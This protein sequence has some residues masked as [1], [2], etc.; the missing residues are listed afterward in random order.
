[1]ASAVAATEPSLRI[2]LLGY[3]SAP[4]SGGQGI[5][6]H[7]LSRAL[8]KLGHKV[9][10]IS[11]PPYPHLVPEVAL[12]QLP[13][14]DL[15]ANGLRSVPISRLLTD[16]LA[17]VE[18]LSKLTGGFAEPWTFAERARRWLLPRLDQF[19]VIHDNQTLADGLLAIQAAG[20]PLVTTIHHPISRDR[21]LALQ[22]EPSWYR[23][24]LVARWHDFVTMQSRV[25]RNLDHIVTVSTASRHDIAADF[26]VHPNR[27]SVIHIGVDAAL[28]RPLPQIERAPC[29]IMATASA[30][31]PNKGLPILLRAAHQLLPTLPE[32]K[33]L[34][35]GKPQPGGSTEA[36]V[37]ELGMGDRIEWVHSVDHE[38]IVA[39]YARSTV[40]VVPSLYEGFGLPAVEAMACAMP[41][42]VSDGGALPE[43]AG[44]AAQVVPAGDYEALAAALRDLLQ[45]KSRRD[46]LGARAR[47][48][49]EQH[50]SWDV[51][52]ERMVA[53]Y[54][55]CITQC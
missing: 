17:R 52:A 22:A 7:Y 50:F 40:A 35:V 9:T 43:V 2:A 3:R 18:W 48:R 12:E 39:H 5:Y 23:R 29:Q 55:E 41:L 49:A 13:S 16:A 44:D 28:F 46:A 38:T 4:F 51:C 14:L 8:T 34:L 27:I 20:V 33:L 30:D 54:R 31:T 19:D 11:G 10:V 53:Y 32:L 26:G 42:V 15:Y 37:A 1:M 6:L 45:N 25:A 36:L 24:L 47:L 21:R